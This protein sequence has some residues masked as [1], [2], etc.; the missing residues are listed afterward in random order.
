M[1]RL[2]QVILIAS[3]IVASWLGMQAVHELGHC[4]GAWVSGGQVAKVV[5]YPLTISRTDLAYNPHPL[6]VVWSGPVIGVLLPL[7]TWGVTLAIRGPGAFV[8]RF[9]AGFCMVANGAYIAFGSFDGIGDCGTMLRYGSPMWS[10]WLLAR[11]PSRLGC[12]SGIAK[13][14]ISAWA[15]PKARAT[16]TQPTAPWQRASFWWSFLQHWEGNESNGQNN[17][18]SRRRQKHSFPGFLLS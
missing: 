11:S 5:W 13:E 4:L 6:L 3:V 1:N 9:F 14:N 16:G 18:E 2:H 12:G 10:L 8:N 7:A 17:K 15:P